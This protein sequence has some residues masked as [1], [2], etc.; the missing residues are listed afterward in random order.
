MAVYADTSSLAV[1]MK[2][3]SRLSC[4]FTGPAWILRISSRACSFGSGTSILRSR[5]PWRISAGPCVSG[6]LIVMISFVRPRESQPSFW[7]NN[8]ACM[9]DSVSQLA[10]IPTVRWRQDGQTSINLR[11]ISRSAFVPSADLR[12]STVSISSMKMIQGLWSRADLNISCTT[13]ADSLMYLSMMPEEATLRKLVS[14]PDVARMDPEV[15]GK[16]GQGWASVSGV[17]A[18]ASAG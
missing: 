18:S 7:F 17:V 2:L 13:C 6:R 14:C 5:R 4:L 12:P 1:A 10:R 16:P 3:E 11:W 15:W 9:Q 8:C